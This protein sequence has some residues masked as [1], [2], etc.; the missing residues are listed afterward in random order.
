MQQVLKDV[1]FSI[2]F[3]QKVAILGGSGDGKTTLLKLILG[4]LRPDSGRIIIAGEDITDKKEDELREIRTKFSIVFQ[5][6]ALFDSLN[7]KENVAFGLREYTKMTEGEIDKKVRELLGEVGLEHAI[8]LMPE[9]LS[10]GMLR[11]VAI[12]RSL[13]AFDPKMFLYDEATTGLDPVNADI[14]CK[15][16]LDLT[17]GGKG[18]IIVTHKVFDALRLAERFMFLKN[19]AIIFDGNRD[20]LM[21]SPFVEIQ[22]FLKELTPPSEASSR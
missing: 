19:G 18:F 8:E 20:Q 7:V 21:Q 11:R 14:I 1:S 9:E 13:A 10:G 16:I 4:L 12:M 6:G 5:E 17:K 22:V 2:P 15:L 3:N